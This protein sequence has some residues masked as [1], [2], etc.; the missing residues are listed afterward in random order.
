MFYMSQLICAMAKDGLLFRG[1]AQIHAR[2]GTPVMAVM[3]SVNLAGEYMKHTP[4][5]VN[6]LTWIFLVNSHPLLHLV[7][8]F[9][10]AMMALLLDL[11]HIVEHMSTGMIFSNILG[12]FSVLVLR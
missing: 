8:A 5:P 6:F 9:I 10:L 3:S 2:T 12:T 4:S 1:L 11:R 7:C